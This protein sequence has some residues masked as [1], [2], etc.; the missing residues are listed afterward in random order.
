MCFIIYFNISYY[1]VLAYCILLY[2]EVTISLSQDIFFFLFM[3]L[4]R[5]PSNLLMTDI[6][7]L[8]MS[9]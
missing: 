2:E 7:I 8:D 1:I 9:V 4:Y 5:K 6:L 3:Y